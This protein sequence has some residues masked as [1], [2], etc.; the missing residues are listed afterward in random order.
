M[1]RISPD[2]IHLFAGYIKDLTGIHLDERK[3]YLFETRLHTLVVETG[4]SS[5]EELYTIITRDRSKR[6]QD[7]VIDLMT[8]NETSFFRDASPFELLEFKLLPDFIDRLNRGNLFTPLRLK[9]WSAACSFGQEVYSISIVLKKILGD[10]TKHRVSILG[11]D[12]SDN[13]IKRASAGYYKRLEVERGLKPGDLQ[14]YFVPH[15]NE[16]KIDDELRSLATFKRVNLLED[17]SFL[18]RFDMIFCRNVSAYF[19]EDDRKKL[20]NNLAKA[21]NPGGVL[22]IGGTESIGSLCP[23]F[24]SK[25]YLRTIYY[26][27][28][29]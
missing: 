4:A 8:T 13:A 23:A 15:G 3:S 22:V 25:R 26:Q 27:L 18:G 20:F 16:W 12:I 11:T 9:I 29:S 5:F 6:Y 14:K 1:L 19:D 21:L 10:T 17:F 24:E 7:Q 28:K 2:E